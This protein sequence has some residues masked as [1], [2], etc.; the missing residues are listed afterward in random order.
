MARAALLHIAFGFAP[1]LLRCLS[2]GGRFQLHPGAPSLGQSNRDGLLRRSRTM[3]A[4]ANV[5]HFLADELSRLRRRSLAFPLVL[6]SSFNRFTL[7]HLLLSQGNG[8]RSSDSVDDNEPCLSK[9]KRHA[10]CSS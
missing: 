7:R 2:L 6:A 5:M 1:C 10:I 8:V 4:F 9:G 3:L